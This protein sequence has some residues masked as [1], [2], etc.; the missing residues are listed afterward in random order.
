MADIFFSN[1]E[2]KFSPL[3]VT[4]ILQPINNNNDLSESFDKEVS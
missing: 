3:Q 2:A 4:T 1:E